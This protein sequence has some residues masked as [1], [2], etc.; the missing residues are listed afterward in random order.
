MLRHSG[1]FFEKFCLYGQNFSYGEKNNNFL[2]LIGPCHDLNLAGLVCQPATDNV[3]HLRQPAGRSF[4]GLYKQAETSSAILKTRQ[5]QESV[6]ALRI[7]IIVAPACRLG[8]LIEY[9]QK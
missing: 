6:I 4:G 3:G 9:E 7:A 5:V 1:N 2:K 8:G